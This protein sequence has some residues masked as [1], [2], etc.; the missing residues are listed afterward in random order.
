MFS[1]PVK[2]FV[3]QKSQGDFET[4]HAEDGMPRPRSLSA[5]VFLDKNV[6]WLFKG[7]FFVEFFPQHFDMNFLLSPLFEAEYNG[8]L[9]VVPKSHKTFLRCPGRQMSANWEKSLQS[10]AEPHNMFDKTWRDSS[11][12]EV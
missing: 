6:S 4:W 3:K 12:E 1:C 11:I 10:Q 8:A 7:P 2:I 5:V 9:M